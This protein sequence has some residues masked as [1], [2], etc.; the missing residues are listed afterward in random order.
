MDTTA[1]SAPPPADLDISL[2]QQVAL[3]SAA[4]RLADEFAG[5]F[6]AATIERFLTTSYDEFADRATIAN[7]LPL[8]G[9]LGIDPDQPATTATP[10]YAG[11]APA[12]GDRR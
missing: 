8:L 6:N 12:A 11:A 4:G 7:F 10:T 1:D 3:R 5:T 9:E 2:D